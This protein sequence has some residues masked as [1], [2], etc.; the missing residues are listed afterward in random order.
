MREAVLTYL[1]QQLG[2]VPETLDEGRTVLSYIDSL[3][4]LEVI[5]EIEEHF[6]V[7]LD[8]MELFNINTVGDFVDSVLRQLDA[9][10][11]KPA[12]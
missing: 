3:R 9:T 6:A 10:K 4:Q 5:D 8:E 1:A 12:T 11:G 7:E 2:A